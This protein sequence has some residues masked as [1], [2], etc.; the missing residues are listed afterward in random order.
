M[1]SDDNRGTVFDQ[2]QVS[3]FEGHL[4]YRE[5]KNDEKWVGQSLSVSERYPPQ[6]KEQPVFCA[7][8]REL[9]LEWLDH[10]LGTQKSSN[11]Q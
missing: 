1:V 3:L 7:R 2:Q 10:L 11:C 4:S 8:G 9:T 6:L 5:S